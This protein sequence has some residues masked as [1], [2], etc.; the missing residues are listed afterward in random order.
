MS[1]LD[2]YKASAGSGKTFTL[3]VHYIKLLVMAEEQGEYAH[4]LA[5]TFTN[6]ATTEMKDRILSQLYGIGYSLQ[7]S[8]SYFSALKA[9]LNGQISPM[10]SDEELRHRCRVALHQILHDYNRFR[11]QTIDAFF[12]IILRG[13][14]HELGLTANLQVEISDAEVL[15]KAVDRIVDRLQ[16]EPQIFEW[17][18]SLVRDRIVSDQKW[19][20]TQEVKNFGRAIFNED[21]LM[22]GEQLRQ[23][24]ADNTFMRTFIQQLLNLEKSSI[25]E[26]KSMGEH[27]DSIIIEAGVS[28][29]DFSNGATLNGFVNH[30][31]NG[32]ID[33]N[34]GNRVKE[35][36]NDWS[37]LLRKSDKD[38]QSVISS[39]ARN[40]G[41]SLSRILERLGDIQRTV[42]S[43]RLAMAHLKQLC[44]LDAIDREVADINAD[45]SRFNLAKTPILLNRMVG[46]SDAPFIFEKMG[47]MLKH[48]MID[49][50]QDTSSL[51]WE[52]F[53][54]LLLES[55]S[56][57]GRNLIVG[58][59]KQSIYRWRGG[60]W[61]I[62]GTIEQ[63][64]VP[65]PNVYHLDVNRRSAPNIIHFNNDFFAEAARLLDFQSMPESKILDGALSFSSAYADVKQQVPPSPS[66]GERSEGFVSVTVLDS[67]E[68]CKRDDW[69]PVILDDLK[70]QVRNMHNIGLPYSSM[71]ILVR[72]N[73]DMEPIIESFAD[74]PDMPPIV[75]DEAFLY[76]SS[77]AVMTLIAALRVLDN[78]DD[79]VSLY[80]LRSHVET[81]P[82]DGL[83]PLLSQ[84]PLYEL[85]E[86]LYRDLHLD[87]LAYQDA[88]ILGF[89]DAVLDYLHSE[90]SDIHSFLTYWDEHLS[91]QTIPAGQVDGIRIITIHKAKGLEFHTVLMPFCTWPFERDRSTDLLWC[92]PTDDPFRELE[93]IPITPNSK[94]APNSIFARDYAESHLLSRLDELNAL[95]VGFTRPAHNFFAWAVG[96]DENFGK[97]SRTIGDLIASVLPGGVTVGTPEFS[98]RSRDISE[99]R[100]IP[101]PQPLDVKMHSYPISAT[102][103]QS[104]RSQDFLASLSTS[105]DESED[106]TMMEHSRQSQYIQLGNLLHS[107]LQQI[108]SIE[109]VARV[110]D[111]MEQ[112]GVISR[113]APDGTYV[114][115]HRKDVEQW[116][117]RGFKNPQVASWFS[118]EW[119]L[120][121]E[122]SIIRINPENHSLEK[123]RPDRV[124]VSA[125]KSHIIVV[126]FKFGRP[127]PT[128]EDQV[129]TYMNLLAE[130][131]PKA[132][133]DGF[134]WYVYSAVVNTVTFNANI[135]LSRTDSQQILD[136]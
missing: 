111:H 13:L 133:V 9:S 42:N 31:K 32:D 7:D 109:D 45:T 47:A 99:N 135:G 55:M 76:S 20:V 117:E 118:N 82:S 112:Q 15:S 128:Y 103:R 16:D 129:R 93:L 116:L 97:S 123:L 114:S 58:D 64:M 68:Y 105:K 3:A 126:D 25:N 56:K 37:R 134:L 18:Y 10:P 86:T 35:W 34:V 125:D 63:S 88:Y 104:N 12:Q 81:M 36:A 19:D 121:T 70:E 80:Y 100:L 41:E 21:Y 90:S 115:V 65:K 60:D 51:Q 85:L 30:L 6:K 71:T 67:K 113:Y 46:E 2:V 66:S 119:S 5:V 122:C 95:Y 29:L 73:S 33:I 91:R 106:I 69:Q 110:L 87:S 50:F 24:L 44:L 62:L 8:N 27:I 59:V 38:T 39:T 77:P 101:R 53:K 89:F 49:E 124:M 108:N 131:Y 43:V 26:I 28:Y 94:S 132:S 96:N 74:D 17:L 107:I 127:R 130:M 54:V 92:T 83:N 72:N 40:V 4:I 23:R 120:F 98:L 78:P 75:S 11:V 22:R 136:F 14:A 52:N 79:T 1:S 48:V 84:R 102:F 57:G 61:R